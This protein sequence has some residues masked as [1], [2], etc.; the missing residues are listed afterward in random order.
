[1][2]CGCSTRED[3]TE[4]IADTPAIGLKLALSFGSRLAL[5]DNYLVQHHL[6]FMPALS[7]LS[8]EI[9]LSVARRLIPVEKE[10]S[11]FIVE[12][13]Q[14]P[15]ALFIVESGQV[16]L[17]SSEEGGDFSELGQGETFG[18]MALLTGRPHAHTA[19]AA[20]DVILWALPAAEFETLTQD[21][22]EVR[23]AFSK[24]F[25]EPLLA[26]DMS[27]A[28]ER[29]AAMPIFANLSED[30]LWS[31]A[32]RMLVRHVPAGELV[33]DSGA[34]GDAFYLIDSGQVEI[35]SSA[36]EGRS[37]LARLGADQFFG[38]MALLTGKPRSM[39]ARAATHSNLWVL[40]RSDF[41]D[42]VNRHPS[43][44]LALSKILSE[45]LAEM[46][47]R[48]TEN[49][50]RG[51]K[52]LAGLSPGQLED[53]SRKLQPTRF[54][55]GEVIVREGDPGDAMFFIESG[56]VRVIRDLGP[57]TLVLAEM[58]AGDLFGEM[59]LL[60]GNPRSAT[61]TAHQRRGPLGPVAVGL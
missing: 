30:V 48:F 43:I 22:P 12:A 59:A 52:L 4:L 31:V 55:Q 41:D 24:T 53:V 2:S 27:R 11:E 29:L 46:D 35:V 39:A 36:R 15:E 7:G 44:S 50:L 28:I 6:K 25:R 18:E 23:L 49:H 8:D 10:K 45:R 57:R 20:T 14:S 38:E 1:M 5:F 13:G 34:P 32:Q 54:R 60:T 21:R 17:L 47:R 40:Y 42:L 26:Q 61:V 58:A 19:Q 33:F 56:R 51:L 16:H 3:L 9:L 37:V